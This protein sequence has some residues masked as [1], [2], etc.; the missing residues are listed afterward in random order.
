M[1]PWIKRWR[2]WAMHDLWPLSR[3]AAQ[4]QALGYSFEKAGLTL[5]GQPIP[6]NA[7]AV[8]V[9]AQ[10]RRREALRKGDFA[11]RLAG[12]EPLPADGLRR[13]DADDRHRL[14]F[15]FPPPPTTTTAELL[16]RGHA[17]GQLTLPILDAATFVAGLRLQLPTLF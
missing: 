12:C 1:W 11:L 13:D 4:P 2:D 15:R 14:F 3:I 17:L 7:E 16:W 9:E 10:L 6:W 8:L 5:H